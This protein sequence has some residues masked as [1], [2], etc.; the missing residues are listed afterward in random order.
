M[1]LPDFID[2]N[3]ETLA[4]DWV[5]QSL[6]L[7][8]TTLS[9]RALDASAR[10]LLKALAQDMRAAQSDAQ[11][12][13]EG[14]GERSLDAPDVTREARRHADDRLA[15]GSSLNDVVAEY[16]ALRASVAC[17]W[18]GTHPNEDQRRLAE[19]VRFD[20]VVDRALSE[21]V[22]HYAA[23]LERTRDLFVGI[24]VHDLRT[25]LGAIAMAAQLLM[26][27]DDLP[28]QALRTAAT[29]QR[30]GAR[31]QRIIDDLTDFTRTR[32]RG[33]LPIHVE[34]ANMG[35]I[36]RQAITEIRALYPDETVRWVSDGDLSGKWDCCRLGQ[37][38]T[39]LLE[40]A[41]D[42]GRPG[43]DVIVTTHGGEGTVEL[44]V[45]NEGD[46]IPPAAQ[47]VIFD[48]LTR[49]SPSAE[50]RR[51]SAGLGLGLFIARQ[52]ALAHGGTLEVNSDDNGTTFT[53][54]LLRMLPQDAPH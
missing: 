34:P 15:R 36:C 50:P 31:M 11:Q 20:E 17:R 39:N 47:Q 23:G 13:V 32:L 26:H 2:A 8:A 7:G 43:A 33:L 42:H 12:L 48:P 19:L 25:P 6:R 46:P 3:V 54:S 45:F 24:L 16:R 44:S 9:A 29:V 40:N 28:A 51:V 14:P 53:A 5:D 10:R 37:L 4:I 49:T 35:N 41:I 27:L 21:A 38:L 30:S 18:L 1:M 52:I 22:E